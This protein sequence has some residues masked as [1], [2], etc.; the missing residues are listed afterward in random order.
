VRDPI[1]DG[2]HKLQIFV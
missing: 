1:I 2:E